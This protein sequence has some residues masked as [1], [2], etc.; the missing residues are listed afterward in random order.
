MFPVRKKKCSSSSS[1]FAVARAFPTAR[2]E[3]E[4]K[5]KAQ[6][7]PRFSYVNTKREY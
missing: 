3:K 7:D 2:C 4:E 6:K 5:K 1:S